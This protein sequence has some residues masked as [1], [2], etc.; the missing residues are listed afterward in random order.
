MHS[1]SSSRRVCEAQRR[2]LDSFS[3]PLRWIPVGMMILPMMH[4]G[5]FDTQ[6]VSGK[7]PSSYLI[8]LKKKI[9]KDPCI[10]LLLVLIDFGKK[11][12]DPRLLCHQHFDILQK[13]L[14]K[15]RDYSDSP[16]NM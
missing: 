12:L 10:L 4:I 11:N 15:F 1:S 7:N 5:K 9:R 16:L 8:Y 2:R 3:A 13:C 14:L 6:T